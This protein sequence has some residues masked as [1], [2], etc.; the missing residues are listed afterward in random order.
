MGV[1]LNANPRPAS[2]SMTNPTP[3]MDENDH[4]RKLSYRFTDHDRAKSAEARKR[5]DV[6]TALICDVFCV[7]RMCKMFQT[8]CVCTLDPLLRGIPTRNVQ[9]CVGKIREIISFMEERA[10]RNLYYEQLRGG[11]ARE[12]VTRFIRLLIKHHLLLARLYQELESKNKT[13]VLQRGTVLGNIFGVGRAS[14]NF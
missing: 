9:E 4:P 7:Q 8:G 3:L 2:P 6:E 11:K 12:R 13:I 14:Q 1:S 5:Q 10:W